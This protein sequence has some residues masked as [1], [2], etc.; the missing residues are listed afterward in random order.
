[1][2]YT[3]ISCH[4]AFKEAGLQR[5]HYK[6]D[7]HR[8]N[9]KRKVAELPPVSAETF[10]ERVLAQRAELA[11][12]E[13]AQSYTA[14]CEYCRKKFS[15]EKS[16]NNH[17]KSN[18]HQENVLVG[19]QKIA[20]T[21]NVENV[22][23]IEDEEMEEVSSDEWEDD[24]DPIPITSCLFCMKSSETMEEN[25]QHMSI[26]HS[27]FIPDVE[28]ITDMEGL[29]SYLGEKV[30]QGH[31]CLWCGHKGRQFPS[32]NAVQKHMVDKGHCKMFHEGEVLLEYA[33]FYDYSSSYPDQQDTIDQ[34]VEVNVLDDTGFQLILPSGASI[35]HRS[36]FRY[37]RQKLNPNPRPAPARNALQYANFR[38]LGWTSSSKDVIE[39]KARDISFMR[40]VFSKHQLNLSLKANK[41]QKHFRQQVDF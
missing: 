18:K 17:V 4:V 20:P 2:S 32:V 34:E 31:L 16:Y 28:Y 6:T 27:F 33:D 23:E 29:M 38:A 9:L 25:L 24:E 30:G 36:L 37:Y 40:K 13:A 21:T 7:W 10:Q 41:L 11:K 1:M 15:S 35:G 26:Y 39:K 8:Y 3:C 5:E 12:N 22:E 19:V 14:Y